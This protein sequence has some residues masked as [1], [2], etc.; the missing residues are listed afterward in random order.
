MPWHCQRRPHL[1]TSIPNFSETDTIIPA[2]T[3][4]FGMTSRSHH[5][6]RRRLCQT[7]LV[8]GGLLVGGTTAVTATTDGSTRWLSW[9]LSGVVADDVEFN[10]DR[11]E[12]VEERVAEQLPDA[13]SAAV[14]AHQSHDDSG[15][16]EV[17]G[18]DVSEEEF[19]SA[20]DD[21]GYSY[22]SI[23]AGS[24]QQTRD[25]IVKIL[26]A[27]LDEEGIEATVYEAETESE[28]Y[29][30]VAVPEA[31]ESTASE[32]LSSR[33]A[34]SID[35]YY[36]DSD[37]A[38]TDETGLTRDDFLSVGSATDDAQSGPHVPVSVDADA[39]EAFQQQLVD[40]GVAQEG[41]SQCTYE[42]D[43]DTTDPCLL[44]V[45][46]ETVRNSFGMNPGLAETMRDGSWAEDPM[47][48]LTTRSL[49]EAQ[50]IAVYLRSGALPVEPS[51][52]ASEK[53]P[54]AESELNERQAA[55][56]DETNIS[57]PGFGIGAA[58]AALGA[59][60]YAFGRR[61]HENDRK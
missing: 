28:Q 58:L 50:Q 32:L 5:L 13:D 59:M 49:E 14:F 15:A 25:E 39:A 10:G 24:T 20:L 48:V 61:A 35:I 23:T 19:R 45:E 3:N 6:S 2:D 41:G 33:G 47:F 56:E 42:N 22:E 12:L 38:Y 57:A 52:T 55:S 34:V 17:L 40:T 18:A 54:V 9:S 60:G 27:R 43:P 26:G 51:L 37:G 7:G 29:I 1:S 30:V 4:G 46:D 11:L 8:A 31:D 21:S 44:L 53:P 36:Y 16:L